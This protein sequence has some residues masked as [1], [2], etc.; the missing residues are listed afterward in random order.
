MS[1]EA[2]RSFI[3]QAIFP[4]IARAERLIADKNIVAGGPCPD[5]S[6]FA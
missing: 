6:R 3:E 5:G 1:P 4:T 2:A